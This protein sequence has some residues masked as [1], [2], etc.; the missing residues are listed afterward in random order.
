[1]NRPAPCNRIVEAVQ[2]QIDTYR[3]TTLQDIYKSFSQDAFGPGHLIEDASRTRRYIEEEL[4]SMHSGRRHAIEPCGLGTN[5]CRVPMD[6]ICD[7]LVDLDT[8]FTNFINSLPKCRPPAPHDW[9]EGWDHILGCL[10]ALAPTI[11]DFA[12]DAARITRSL[13]AGQLVM[14]HS[15]RYVRTHDPHYRIFLIDSPLVFAI[16]QINSPRS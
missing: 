6:I 8:Y 9:L 4:A 15:S 13:S 5:F 1:M 7:G 11:P 2:T 3:G 16:G 12:S 10:K 14:H